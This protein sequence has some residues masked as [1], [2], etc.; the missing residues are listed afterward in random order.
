[1]Y[2]AF[3]QECK[4]DLAAKVVEKARRRSYNKLVLGMTVMALIGVML[5]IPH[6]RKITSTISWTIDTV[7]W[8]VSTCPGLVTGGATLFYKRS[9]N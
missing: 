5:T 9:A 7:Y 6:A 8:F 4:F 2:F 3:R 1:M